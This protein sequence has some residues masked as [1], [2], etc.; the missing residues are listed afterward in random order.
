MTGRPRL[1]LLLHLVQKNNTLS[2]F[3]K[4]KTWNKRPETMCLDCIWKEKRW[5]VGQATHY[6]EYLTFLY[7]ATADLIIYISSHVICIIVLFN[8]AI[9]QDSD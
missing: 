7:L 6:P 1:T 2:E 4:E 3:L 9:S 8:E 5:N